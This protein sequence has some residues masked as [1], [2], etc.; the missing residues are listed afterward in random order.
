MPS[1][2]AGHRSSRRRQ[3][4]PSLPESLMRATLA[5]ELWRTVVTDTAERADAGARLALERE[6]RARL[7]RD[8]AVVLLTAVLCLLLIHFFGRPGVLETWRQLSTVLHLEQRYE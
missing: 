1:A 6:G 8:A 5:A 3:A 2:P 7:D 4:T